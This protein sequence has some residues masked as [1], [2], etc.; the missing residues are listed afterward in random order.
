MDTKSK[1]FDRSIISKTIAFFLAMLFIFFGTTKAVRF[2]GTNVTTEIRN[3]DSYFSNILTQGKDFQLETSEMFATEYSKFIDLALEKS[4]IFGNGTKEDYQRYQNTL[5][6][7]IDQR[8]ENDRKDIIDTVV[9]ECKDTNYETTMNYIQ[10]GFI[11]LTRI[12]PHNGEHPNEGYH[13][14][15]VDGTYEESQVYDDD[16]DDDVTATTTYY[17]DITVP[18]THQ[19]NRNT[20]SVNFTTLTTFKAEISSPTNSSSDTKP[21]ANNADAVIT[22]CNVNFNG[23]ELD[24][25]YAVHSNKENIRDSAANS[26]ESEFSYSYLTIDDDITFD[27]FQEYAKTINEQLAEYKGL[28]F[29]FVDEQTGRIVSNFNS[30]NQTEA[31]LKEGVTAFP[32]SF[33]KEEPYGINSMGED[34]TK[35]A[36]LRPDSTIYNHGISPQYFSET[37]DFIG[38]FKLY[39]CFD[40]YAEA[41]VFA[42]MEENYAQIYHDVVSVFRYEAV[43]LLGFLICVIILVVKSGRRHSDDELHMMYVDRIP[44][45]LRT[46]LSA[47]IIT[48]LVCLFGVTIDASNAYSINFTWIINLCALI[49]AAISAFLID[50]ILYIT[51]HIKNHSLFSSI[52]IVVI[53]KAAIKS[54]KRTH[55][56]NILRRKER[57]EK[58]RAAPSVYKDIY[59][60]TLRKILLWLV[61]PNAIIGFLDLLSAAY[62]ESGIAFILS[63]L[64]I[65]YDIAAVV[66]ILKYIYS[67]RQIFHAINQAANG[68]YNIRLDTSSMPS[69]VKAYAEN[70]MSL[71]NGIQI[72]VDEAVKEQRM[73]TELITNVSHDL[74]TPLTSIITYVDLL[75]RCNIE[76]ENAKEYIGVLGDKSA[77]LKRLIEDLVEASKAS[78]GAVNVEL[79]RVS[80][81]ELTRQITG[82]YSDE[83]ESRNLDLIAQEDDNEITVMADSKL[84]YR[85]FDN[86]M[87]NVKKYAMP[88]TRVYLRI[89]KYNGKGIL[90]LRNIS[91]KPLNIPAS[92]LMARF[93]RGDESRSSDG[94]GLGLSIAENFCTLQG[95]KLTLEIN[96]D[97][98]TATVE[99]RLAD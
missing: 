91:E 21:V 4:V 77:R 52:L 36:S 55:E 6:K 27:Q 54:A 80:L 84:C 7:L 57:E 74:K 53:I 64:L 94:N 11:S 5:K 31:Q 37:S 89:Y 67:L 39:V 87:S 98:F 58:R 19:G 14:D 71:N 9:S 16:Y 69:T 44:P 18:S 12:G 20:T 66:Y 76:D 29:G 85:V 13:G 63:I 22:L 59:K 79:I 88:G 48:G 50:W 33:I 17:D 96:G 61:A 3:P 26:I 82:E 15:Y 86:L 60:D 42:G 2:L 93:V 34:F 92:E 24:G 95:G 49:A 62:N 51:R 97:L 45:I 25:Y 35:F 38:Q 68:N 78:S 40:P 1:K 8:A 83:L 41:D 90:T 56:K 81:N 99:Y 10:N 30:P 75:S 47:G 28:R 70:V 46:A 43:M 73:K 72:A 23:T 32:W 65:A